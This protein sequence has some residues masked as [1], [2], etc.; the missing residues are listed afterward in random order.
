MI[1]MHKL[2]YIQVKKNLLEKVVI[3]QRV[4]KKKKAIQ[5]S[6]SEMK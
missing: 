3:T 5:E 2:R 4:V 1:Y 6:Q